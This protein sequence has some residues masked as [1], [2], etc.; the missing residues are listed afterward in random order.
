MIIRFIFK[1]IVAPI[2]MVL[3]TAVSAVLGFTGVLS[4]KYNGNK[5][6]KWMA[7]LDDNTSLREVNMPGSHDTMALY[8]IGNLAGQCQSLS[9][10]DQLNLGVR[11]LDIRLKQEGDSLKA[12]HGFVDQKANFDEINDTVTKFLTDNPSEFIIMSVKEESDASK[13]IG[14]F[15]DCLK[16]KIN[17]KYLLN[18]TLP[19]KVGDIRGKVV[20]LSRYP[21]PTIGVNAYNGWA[22]STSFTLPGSDIYIQD[23]YKITSPEQKV[24]AIKKCFNETGHALKINFLSAYRTNYIPPSYAPSAALDINVWINK[25]IGDYSDRNIVLYDFVTEANMN[26]FFKGVL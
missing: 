13:P 26:E 3:A 25:Y 12:V 24:D 5:Y 18:T 16:S 4:Q 7:G 19:N 20:L 15:E 10:A 17:G 21:N 23:E 1:R 11:F 22:D 8:S 9:L 2:I 14:S 6:A